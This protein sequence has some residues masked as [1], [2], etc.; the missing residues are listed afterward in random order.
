MNHLYR[1]VLPVFL[2]LFF[3]FNAKAVNDTLTIGQVFNWQVGDSF[4]YR[5]HQVIL[6]QGLVYAPL[7]GFT[8][9]SR[10]DYPDS[11]DYLV[12]YFNNYQPNQTKHFTF[13]KM[14]TVVNRYNKQFFASTPL[15][16]PPTICTGQLNSVLSTYTDSIINSLPAMY[17][18]ISYPD[19]QGN[20]PLWWHTHYAEGIGITHHE[21]GDVGP[22]EV[23]D[24]PDYHGYD[25]AYY[26]KGNT[27]WMDSTLYIYLGT[28]NA[29]PSAFRLTPNPA[30]SQLTITTETNEPVDVFVYDMLGDCVLTVKNCTVGSNY[31]KTEAFPQG[32][33][34]LK[35]TD[36]HGL[37]SSKG[38]IIA[39]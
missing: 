13:P 31:V 3:A 20:V 33:Y 9:V 22:V 27:T 14:D 36:R 28:N 25:L 23:A 8:V 15:S 11:I 2:F 16:A 26:R 19:T 12:A 5:Y 38:F 24:F 7:V 18:E 32:Y 17:C 1:K 30:N 37:S 34:V 35:L 4:T 21:Y 39:H 29:A 6:G 10:T